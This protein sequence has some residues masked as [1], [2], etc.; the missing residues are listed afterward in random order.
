M[1]QCT[2]PQAAAQLGLSYNQTM[3]LVL[4][5]ALDG[6]QRD[7]RWWVNVSSVDRLVRER[8]TAADG[9]SRTSFRNALAAA[10]G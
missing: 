8:G 6:E 7:G 2:L 4:V 10:E 5:R 9:H 1:K 3:R